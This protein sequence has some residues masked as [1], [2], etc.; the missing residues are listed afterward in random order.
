MFFGNAEFIYRWSVISVWFEGNFWFFFVRLGRFLPLPARRSTSWE[1]LRCSCIRPQ[2]RRLGKT[3]FIYFILEQIGAKI[4]T[5]NFFF[6]FGKNH[7]RLTERETWPMKTIFP[8]DLSADIGRHS[9]IP[10]AFRGR[11]PGDSNKKCK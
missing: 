7:E 10:S 3:F 9:F 5:T 6:A 11:S 1:N 2:T 8:S 4:C